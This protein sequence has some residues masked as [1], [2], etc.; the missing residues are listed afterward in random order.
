[1]IKFLP[2]DFFGVSHRILCKNENAVYRLQITVLVPKLFKFE[3][4]VSMQMRGVKQL[5]SQISLASVFFF[6]FVKKSVGACSQ[7]KVSLF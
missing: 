4:C 2:L 5:I 1:M 3:K 7:F 6:S